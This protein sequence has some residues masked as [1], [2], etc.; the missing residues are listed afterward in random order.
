MTRPNS[1]ALADMAAMVSWATDPMIARTLLMEAWK[2]PAT[3]RA[4]LKTTAI[5][6]PASQAAAPKAVILWVAFSTSPP[7]DTPNTAPMAR[8]SFAGILFDK[9]PT[10]LQSSGHSLDRGIHIGHAGI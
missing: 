3:S 4:R 8:S 10:G 7:I 6:R 1:L 2:S 9:P 5:F